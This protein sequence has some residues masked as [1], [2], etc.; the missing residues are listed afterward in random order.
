[1]QAIIRRVHLLALF[2]CLM[3]FGFVQENE[4]M[5]ELPCR[6]ESPTYS[7]DGNKPIVLDSKT[8]N[9]RATYCEPLKWTGVERLSISGSVALLILA[10]TDGN[11]ECIKV[12]S[13]HPLLTGSAIEAAKK[14]KFKPMKENEKA[15]AF[16]GMLI[17][18]FSTGSSDHAPDRCLCAH[19]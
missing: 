17:F 7:D 14:W 9:D 3:P 16:Y 4:Q 1:M 12:L 2:L 6:T 8:M 18:H 10:G 13:G 5:P 19:S 15:R 11:V